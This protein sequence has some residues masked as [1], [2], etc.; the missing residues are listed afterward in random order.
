[1]EVHSKGIM[2]TL[3]YNDYYPNIEEGNIDLTDVNFSAYVVDDTYNPAPSDKKTDVT[4]K[5]ETL[6]RILI[7]DDISKL[8]MADIT[9]KIISKLSDEE[10]NKAFGFVVYD[11]GTGKLCFYESLDKIENG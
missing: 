5:V 2:A 6:A 7:E 3:I 9:D 8:T 10:R 4:G 1:M 11:I